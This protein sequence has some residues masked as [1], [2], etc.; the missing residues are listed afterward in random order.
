MTNEAY[1]L[2]LETGRLTPAVPA[3]P[4]ADMIL[5][6]VPCEGGHDNSFF[7]YPENDECECGHWKHHVHGVCGHIIQY[8]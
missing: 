5:M 8:G 1:N 2:D 6:D 7:S 3:L 4:E